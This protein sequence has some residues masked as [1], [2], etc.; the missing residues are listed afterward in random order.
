MLVICG[1]LSLAL[2]SRLDVFLGYIV[3]ADI[4]ISRAYIRVSVG[5]GALRVSGGQGALRVSAGQGALSVSWEISFSAAVAEK[6][7]QNTGQ[8]KG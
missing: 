5:Q 8:Q 4:V 7:K 3:T 1:A 2:C 6:G